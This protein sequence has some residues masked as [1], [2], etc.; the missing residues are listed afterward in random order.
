MRYIGYPH[1]GSP[2]EAG[3]DPHCY[4]SLAE[5]RRGFAEHTRKSS[6]VSDDAYMD[7]YAFRDGRQFN[8]A[9]TEADGQGAPGTL[10][11][12]HQSPLVQ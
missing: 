9:W 2:M 8:E 6:W 7:L 4:D 11:G 12:W 1:D 10:P 5:A 3:A